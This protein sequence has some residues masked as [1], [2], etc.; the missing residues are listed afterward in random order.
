M[1]AGA[2]GCY[3][4]G[5]LAR[6]GAPVT[7]VG[8]RVHVEAV[9]REGLFLDSIH[10]QERVAVEASTQPDALRD[11]EVVL[12][13]VK[14]LDTEEAA[15]QLAPHLLPK[16]TVVSL[17][18]GVE[19]VECIRRA[20]GIEALPCVVY[21]G[22]SIPAPGRVKHAGG[23]RLIV[24]S[25][26]DRPPAGPSRNEEVERFAA[27]FTQAGVPCAISEDIT[28][29]LWIKLILNCAGNAVTA[30]GRA[31]YGQV[32]RHE[33]ARQVLTATAEEAIA[34]AKA[35]G[36]RLPPAG[37]AA[38]GLKLAQD[39]GDATSSTAQDVERGKRT[40]IDALNG[41][42]VR[43]AGELNVPV[44]VNRTLYALMKLLEGSPARSAGGDARPKASEG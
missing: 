9:A 15:R 23:G 37:L 7:L 16:A 18:N 13:C 8:R 22:A 2:V 6:A 44:P 27:L 26:P 36:V 14:T 30:L 12:F 42:V 33:L 19:N 25:P 3:F 38:M 40:E 11:A 29:D 31:S 1:G 41:Y 10:F 39:L 28:A 35:A 5:M 24:G 34:V 4:G 17:Q 21:V 32:A 20:T 43:R